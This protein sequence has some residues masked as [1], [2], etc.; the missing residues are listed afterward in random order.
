MVVLVLVT[1]VVVTC[2]CL[3]LFLLLFLS[4]EDDDDDDGFLPSLISLLVLILFGARFC[5]LCSLLNPRPNHWGTVRS[6][7]LF[8]SS[9]EQ[10]S[11]TVECCGTFANSFFFFFHFHLLSS[12]PIAISRGAVVEFVDCLKIEV[13]ERRDLSLSSLSR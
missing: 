7:A 6:L 3:F 1:V 2:T 12:C 13:V 9:T 4:S 10:L 11:P 5:A 8:S